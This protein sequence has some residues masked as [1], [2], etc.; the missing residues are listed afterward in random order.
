[1]VRACPQLLVTRGGVSVLAL[2]VVSCQFL[3][4]SQQPTANSQQSTANSQQLTVFIPPY[5]V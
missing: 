4:V 5:P 1:M 3:V 2:L